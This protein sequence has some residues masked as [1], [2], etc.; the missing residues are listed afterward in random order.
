[1]P[2]LELKSYRGSKVQPIKVVNFHANDYVFTQNW[3]MLIT[4]FLQSYF[5]EKTNMSAMCQKPKKSP[6]KNG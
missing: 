4:C 1:M 5:E 3:F 6:T 2:V